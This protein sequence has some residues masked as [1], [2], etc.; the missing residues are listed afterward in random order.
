MS[1]DYKKI[2]VVTLHQ[3]EAYGGGA[4]HQIDYLIDHLMPLDRYDVYYLAR[5]TDPSAPS[6]GYEIVPIGHKNGTLKFG[7]SIDA[8]S[9][10]RAL[11]TIR[12]NVIYQRVA[13]A[14]TGVCA[15]YARRHGARFV[16]HVAHDSDVDGSRS[17]FGTNPLARSLEALA[18]GYAIERADAI[19]VQTHQQA[20]LLHGNYGREADAVISNFHPKPAET[21]DKSGAATV[22]WIANLKRWKQPEVFVRIAAALQHLRGVRFVMVGAPATASRDRGWNAGLMHAIAATPNLEYLGPR[23]HDQVNELLA[24]SHVLVNTSNQEGFPNTFIQAW[25]REVPVV[26][27][28]NP[29]GVLS[30]ENVGIHARTEEGLVDGVRLLVTDPRKRLE[31]AQ[32]AHVYAIARHSL[33]NAE[34]L[35]R[36]LDK[37]PADGGADADEP[38]TKTSNT[39]PRFVDQDDWSTR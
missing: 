10:Y 1:I 38:V 8:V 15:F 27:F 30:R 25:M 18:V 11:L 35:E 13:C 34:L 31:Y 26:S 5:N 9:L 37:Q 32:R 21:V 2:C 6:T 28:V 16:W 22:L 23:T 33:R 17:L 39:V 24:R 19:V 20:Q 36:L 7:Y 12:P 3:S 14:Y 29:D 4:E